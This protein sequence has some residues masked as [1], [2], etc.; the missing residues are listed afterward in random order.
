MEKIY[1]ASPLASRHYPHEETPTR[2]Q[3]YRGWLAFPPTPTLVDEASGGEWDMSRDKKSKS[4]REG[5]REKRR[6]K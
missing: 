1:T 2:L 3:I 6:Q 5:R 4:D